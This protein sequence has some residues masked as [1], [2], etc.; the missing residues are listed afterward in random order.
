M[1]DAWDTTWRVAAFF[2]LVVAYMAC[3]TPVLLAG[4]LAVNVSAWFWI[5]TIPTSA[6]VLAAAGVMFRLIDRLLFL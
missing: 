1:T 2:G 6:F 5:A 3:C 4:A